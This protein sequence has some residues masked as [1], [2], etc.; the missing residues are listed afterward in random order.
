MCSKLNEASRQIFRIKKRI[1]KKLYEAY[2]DL[3]TLFE[4]EI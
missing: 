2:S 3:I 4:T 1:K